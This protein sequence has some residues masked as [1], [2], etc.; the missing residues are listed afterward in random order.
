MAKYCTIQE[1]KKYL[2][3]NDLNLNP[4]LKELKYFNSE[5]ELEILRK[6]KYIPIEKRMEQKGLW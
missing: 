4:I 5:F 3:Y 2:T 1:Y 6:K